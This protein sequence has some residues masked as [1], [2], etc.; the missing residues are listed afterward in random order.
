MSANTY[1]VEQ[2]L[3]TLPH[4]HYSHKQYTV[5]TASPAFLAF[6]HSARTIWLKIYA[7][8]FK[9]HFHRMLDGAKLLS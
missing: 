4:I 1:T 2:L 3:T 9:H 6:T 5:V 7:Q 8:A